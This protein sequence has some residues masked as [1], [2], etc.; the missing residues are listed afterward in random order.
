MKGINVLSVFDGLSGARVALRELGISVDKY[1]ASEINP[2]AIKLAQHNFSDTIQLGDAKKIE[3][4]KSLDLIIGGSPCQG[5]SINGNRLNFEDE[6]SKLLFEFMRLRDECQPKFWLLENV[7]TMSREIK[8]EIDKLLGVE[9]CVINSNSFSPQNRARIYWTNIPFREPSSKL[10]LYHP[11]KWVIDILE[12]NV[13]EDLLLSEAKISAQKIAPTATDG[14][15]TLNPKKH[16]GSQTYQQDRIYDC[17]GK[18]P[19]LTASLGNR[20]NIKDQHGR[21]RRLSIREQAR[22]QTIPDWYDFSA[23]S[24]LKASEAI[25]NGFTIAAIQYLLKNAFQSPRP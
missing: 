8:N 6:R 25:G 16:D 15:I 11:A 2:S 23:V 14:V 24:D 13:S 19:A 21:I 12:S 22:L 20:F 1:Y 7:A 4:I 3:A 18:F 5:F 10:W 9:G 17:K